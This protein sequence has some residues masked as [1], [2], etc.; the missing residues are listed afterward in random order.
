M[1]KIFKTTALL[2]GLSLL[3][4]LFLAMPLKYF[5]DMPVFVRVIGM[6]HGIL[7][8]LYLMIAFLLKN[9]RNWDLK[10][11]VIICGASVVP[12]GTFYVEKKYLKD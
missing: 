5:F 12:F 8:I 9:E 4:L 2:E 10:T 6:A 11:F 3:L 1:L 7:F